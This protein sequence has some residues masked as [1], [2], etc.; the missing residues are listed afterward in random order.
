M[1]VVFEYVDE[2][3]FLPCTLFFVTYVF[4]LYASSL[5]TYDEVNWLAG[6][7]DLHSWLSLN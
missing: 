6:R 5:T 7:T 3:K 1:F 4:Q 2:M